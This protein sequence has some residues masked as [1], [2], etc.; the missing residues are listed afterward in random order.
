MFHDFTGFEPTETFHFLSSDGLSIACARWNA[1][2][3]AR[4]TIQIAHGMGEHIGRY[5][6]T[7]ALMVEAGF[8]VWANDHRGHGFSVSSSQCLGD[9]GEGGFNLLV[10]DM[11]TLCSMARKQAPNLPLLL[12][13]HS[14]GSFAAQQFVLNKSSEIDGLIL[15]GSGILDGL[16]DLA[17]ASGLEI[18]NAN[19]EPARTP[20]DWLS[21]DVSVVDAF[22]A[23]SLCFPQLNPA[24]MESYLSAASALADSINLS[25]IRSD[26][27]IYIFSGAM[28]PV[29]MQTIGVKELV[30]RYRNAGVMNITVDFYDEGRHE[31]LHDFG[32]EA[33][34][35]N[36]LNWSKRIL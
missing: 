27:P 24:S 8:N 15:S 3:T 29:G 22:L 5:T 20:A 32:H 33:V 2:G 35:Q 12:M 34:K 21:R 10:E 25:N 31:M 13:G 17:A 14:M 26:L 11:F 16:V 6:E 30:N 7:I 18:L 36:L 1:K 9:L 28:D 19:F 23:D 4:G